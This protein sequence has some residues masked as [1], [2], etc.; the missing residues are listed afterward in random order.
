MWGK[1]ILGG[2]GAVLGGPIG[3]GLGA[4]LGHQLFD[5]PSDNTQPVQNSD[6]T[7]PSD[8]ETVAIAYFVC[9]FAGLA[10][11]AKA[12]GRITQ[13]EIEVIE[14]IIQEM[15]LDEEARELAIQVFREAKDDDVHINEYLAQFAALTQYN[16]DTAVLFMNCL[17]AVATADGEISNQEREI[18]KLAEQSLRLRA[19][20]VETLIGNDMSLE[21]AYGLLGCNAEMTDAEVKRQYRKKCMD[22]HPDRLASQGLPPE[23]TKFANEQMTKIHEA[24]E[25]IFSSRNRECVA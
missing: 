1:V 18:L 8:E 7:E 11:L 16:Q 19:G 4:A 10:K 22:F 21:Q 13:D 9:F 3:A 24:Y 23:F 25:V 14:S 15:N 20:T 6:S 2:V 12:D 5:S 17:C